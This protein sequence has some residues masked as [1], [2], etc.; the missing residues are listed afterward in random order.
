VKRCIKTN[1]SRDAIADIST[2]SGSD[3]QRSQSDGGSTKAFDLVAF[4]NLC[5][6][7]VV[8]TENLPPEDEASRKLLLEQL[9]ANPPSQAAWE[10]G[11]NTNTL[12]AA[13]RLGLSV[14]SVG[15]TGND[16]YGKFLRDILLHEGIRVIEPVAPEESLTP[17]Q[18]RTLLC[19]VLVAPDAKHAFCSRYDFGPWPLLSF[20]R[21][22][23]HGVKEILDSTASLFINGFVFDEVP[24][25]VV[26]AAAHQAQQAGAA[27]FFDPGPRAWTFNEGSRR[28][29]L[30]SILDASDV[31]LMTEEEAEAVTGCSDAATA[32][33]FILDRPGARTDW[34][35]IK[36]GQDGALLMA[37]SVGYPSTYEQRALRVDVRDTVGCGDSFAAAV[38]LGYTRRHNIPATMALA[39]AVGAATAMGTGAGRNV[40]RAEDVV[41]L[42]G[43]AVPDCEDGRHQAALSL[44]IESLDEAKF[45][46]RDMD[47]IMNE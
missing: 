18:D 35:V 7:I 37:N 24:S 28:E 22:L 3:P 20:V 21:D 39:S 30:E 19:F 17:E 25:E 46:G 32:A 14:A 5:V 8:Q 2:I 38:I 1:F 13:S 43:A 26:L 29:A 16:I 33:R 40:A 10:V 34:C 27:V 42:L 47:K 31:V 9:T 11:G 6:D 12:I 4:S 23:P 36:R 15:H 45:A 44:L 41:A